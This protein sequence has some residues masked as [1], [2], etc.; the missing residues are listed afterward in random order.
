MRNTFANKIFG[1][2]E[3]KQYLTVIPAV[4]LAVVI[5]LVCYTLG[6]QNQASENSRIEQVSPG[7]AENTLKELRAELDQL[8]EHEAKQPTEEEEEPEDTVYFTGFVRGRSMLTLKNKYAGFVSK[9]NVYSQQRVKKGDVILEYDDLALQT[10]IKKLEYAIREQEIFLERKKLNQQLTRL[11]PLPSEYRNLYWKRKIAQEN[12]E[13]VSNEFDVYE[14]LHDSKIVTDLAYRE[15]KEALMTAEA[16]VKKMDNDMKI[17]KEG[18]ADLYVK[19]AEAEVMEAETKLKNLRQELVMLKEEQK[20]YRITAP[21]D[22]LCIT[23]SDTVGQYDAAGTAAAEVHR[24]DAKL[25]YAYCPESSIRY[26]RE[27]GTYRFISN[28]HPD[29]KPDK[30]F[31]LHCFEIKKTR[32]MYGDESYFLVK[33]KVVKE[34]Q[35]LR[36]GSI[37]TLAVETPKNPPVSM[38]TSP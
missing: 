3:M 11:D 26:V 22:G 28:Q 33:L 32:Y 23:N 2:N 14:Q 16:E 7:I 31:E 25:V 30:G 38:R 6:R 18:L 27:G 35:P 8:K 17:I 19:S 1:K 21:C 5:G 9:I 29:E 37:G 24:D 12:L 34:P 10:S 4:L 36:I 15:K 13:R 20:Y